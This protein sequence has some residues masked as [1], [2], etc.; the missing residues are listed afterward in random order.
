MI[1]MMLT[2]IKGQLMKL[3]DLKLPLLIGGRIESMIRINGTK[4]LKGMIVNGNV[5]EYGGIERRITS[6]EKLIGYTGIALRS[7]NLGRER[8]NIRDIVK[9]RKKETENITA[10]GRS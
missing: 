10:E 1:R 5:K 3:K 6:I 2:L 8:K 4:I 9:R 7:G